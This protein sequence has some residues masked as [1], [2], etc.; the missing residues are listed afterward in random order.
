[1][2]NRAVSR[3]LHTALRLVR[4]AAGVVTPLGWTALVLGVLGWVAGYVWGWREALVLAA[5]ALL[6]FAVAVAFTLGRVDVEATIVVNPSRVV[7]G[8]RAA[9]ELTVTNRRART[10]HS[11]RVELPVGAAVVPFSISRLKGRASVDELFVVPTH[12]R[13]IIPVGPVTTVRGDPLGLMRR[14][15]QWTDVDEIYV[16]P[17]TVLLSTIAAGLIRDLEGQTTPDL[18]PSDVAFH[19]LRPYV[20]GDE[21]RHVHWKSSAKIGELMV[22]QYNDTRRS[23]VAVLLS[24]DTDE[25][26]DDDEFELGVSCAASVA[27]QAMRDEQTVDVIVGD[28]QFPAVNPTRLLDRFSGIAGRPGGPGIAAA[29]QTARRVAP[30]ASVAVACVG[31]ALDV[32]AVRASMVAAGFDVN[33]VVLRAVLGSRPGY[34]RIGRSAFVDVPALDSLGRGLVAVVG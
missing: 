23:H 12:R 29:L 16:H 19:T 15:R 3:H 28:Q 6:L 25:F 1:M 2:V 13:A 30:G 33:T 24:T 20:R 14:V 4:T 27:V 9:G 26:A 8:D 7:V 21:L 32:P 22:R 31:G 10:V 5:A 18:S 17:R 11:L 34:R